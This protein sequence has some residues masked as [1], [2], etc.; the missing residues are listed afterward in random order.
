VVQ[1]TGIVL[2]SNP[3]EN[4]IWQKAL[5]EKNKI[6]IRVTIKVLHNFTGN[7]R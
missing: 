7:D 1:P 5:P 2:V 4:K 3:S 6:K